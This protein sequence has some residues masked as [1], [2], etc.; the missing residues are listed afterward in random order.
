MLASRIA[1]NAGAPRLAARLSLRAWRTDPSDPIA[2]DQFAF[3]YR[4]RRGPLAAWRLIRGWRQQPQA[5][6]GDRAELLVHRARLLAEL[7]DFSA[8]EKLLGQAEEMSS[9]SAWIRLQRAHLFERLDRVEEALEVA[10]AA[11]ALHRFPFYRPGIQVTAHLLQLLDRDDEAIQLLQQADAAL[12]SGPVAGQWYSLLSENGRWSAAESALAR[13]A[14]LSPLLEPPL[15]KWLT[16]QRARTACHLGKRAEAVTFAR[17]LDDEFHRNFVKNLESAANGNGRVQLDVSFV[18]QHFKTCAPATLAALG[19]FWRMPAEHLK[20]AEAMCYDGTPGW[21]QRQWAEQNGWFVREFRVTHESVLALIGAGV[22]FAIS[23]VEATAAHMQAVVGFDRLRGTILLRDPSQPYVVEAFADAFFKYHRAYGPHGMVFLPLAE[24]ARLDGLELPEAGVYDRHHRF[25]LCLQ[26]HDREGAALILAAMADSYHEHPLVW[27]TRLALAGY[28][29]NVSEQLRCLDRLLELFPRAPGRLLARLHCLRDASRQERLE[30]LERSCAAKETDP[31]LFIELARALDDDARNAPAAARW[32]KRALRIRPLDTNAISVQADLLWADGRLEE[33]TELYRFA[34]HLEGYRENLY[35]AWFVA[36]RRTRRTDEAM[37]VLADRFQQFGAKSEQPGMTLAWAWRELDQPARAREIY[38]AAG[39]L[40]PDNG[41]LLL[42]AARLEGR[43]GHWPEAEQLLQ[44]GRDKARKS[45][46]LRAAAEIAE[47]RL[48]TAASLRSAR[49]ILEIEPLALDA[50]SGVARCLAELEGGAAALAHLKSACARFPH[51]YGLRRMVLE[52]CGRSAAEGAET[53]ARGLLQ[54]NPADAWAR[55]ELALILAQA[56][57]FDE[58]LRETTEAAQIEPRNTFSFSTLG[59]LHL[60]RRSPAEAR[61]AFERAIELNVDNGDA[62]NTLLE[63]SP[64]DQERRAALSFI[65]QQL[66]KQVVLGDGLLTFR[67][68]AQPI[69][70]PE[71]LLR[72]LRQAHQAR[73]DLWHAWSALVSQLGHLSQLDEALALAT[74][75]SERFPHL[76]RTWLDLAEVHQ[77]RKELEAELAAA[78]RAVEVNPAWNRGVLALAGALERAGNFAEADEVYARALQHSPNDAQLHAHHAH[79][80]WRR[81]QPAAAFAGIERA[82]RIA[83]GYTWSWDLLH[84]WAADTGQ[85]GRAGDFARTLTRE[86]PGEMHAWLMLARILQGPDTMAER[87][88]AVDRALQLAPREFDAWDLKAT[89]LTLAERFDDAVQAT[90]AGAQ[91]CATGAFSLRG[92]R[93]WVEARRQRLGEAVRLMREVLTE[94]AAYV[95]GWNEL[96]GWLQQ[97]GALV[98]AAAAL[99]TLQRLRPH[100]AGVSR[101]LGFLKLKQ[102]DRPAAQRHFAAALQISATD[103]SSAQNLLS[104]QLG[105]GDLR[106]A[107]ATLRLMQTHQPGAATEAA[108]I[109]FRLR[110]REIDAA[111]AG[112]EKICAGPDPDPWP[113][114]AAADAF[115]RASQRDRVLKVFRRV[116]KS[117]A[118]NPQTAAAAIDLLL[119]AHRPWAAVALFLRLPPGELQRRAAAPLAHGLADAK[120]RFCFR[121]LLW[122]RREMLARDDAA[123]GQVGYALTNFKSSKPAARWLS[124]WRSRSNVEPW[125]LFNLCLGL[126]SLGRYAE[127]GEVVQHIIRK[128]SYRAGS[129][130]LRLFLAVEEA[131]A[132]NVSVAQAHLKQ[133]AIRKQVA[134]DQDLLALARALVEF[135]QAPAAE[136]ARKF[137]AVRAQLAPRFT[138]WR[139]LHV[140]TDVRRTFRRAGRVF[141]WQRGG[142]RAWA[143]FGWR[144]HWQWLLLPL[145]LVAVLFPPLLVGVLLAWWMRRRSR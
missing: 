71:T 140:L 1:V 112:L 63:L 67:Q 70:E 113:V 55:R 97:Q 125:M 81:R 109:F 8:A 136:R 142:L 128:W 106:E 95:W 40:R 111:C 61:T 129:A 100:D 31:A 69:L 103:A 36:C 24:R 59:H 12:Q 45:D 76:P 94:N 7:R 51:H 2:Q 131:L 116:I 123:W 48:D 87:L 99:E 62:L 82:L 34:A 43:L 130:D 104:L 6:A 73:P 88:A 3:H 80:L 105:A 21:Q 102:D 26:G 46:W 52:W 44:A 98:D 93:A 117:A 91:A 42:N 101:Q 126:R 138:P 72:S 64:T 139:L 86:R 66:G 37:A 35:Q 133:V 145:V 143:W 75:A 38:A 83:P 9:Q 118:C 74:Q 5:S 41:Y 10:R 137:K 60:M 110:N 20:L 56:G 141:E 92:R 89:L 19:R 13:Y 78:R 33:A 119:G 58:A 84:A 27:E 47:W 114:G 65:E 90:L 23:T 14:E 135:Q 49:A 127:A 54:I 120:A 28:D 134:Y 22:P 50:H 25:N 85:P 17:Q 32:L 16:S 15:E 4:E 29:A 96:A 57:R 124:D 108:E 18:R 121:W 107:A 30:F 77:W 53:A 144:L 11:C 115:A 39:R 122:R 79:L 132:G 68:L